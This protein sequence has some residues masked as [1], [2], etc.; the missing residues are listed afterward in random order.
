MNLYIPLGGGT[1]YITDRKCVEHILKDNFPNYEKTHHF[2]EF[3]VD[4]L[5]YGV[6]TTDGDLWKLHRKTASHFFSRNLLREATNITNNKM[7]EIVDLMNSRLTNPSHLYE[8]SDGEDTKTI[9]GG[10]I[11]IQDIFYRMT[12]DIIVQMAFGI[13]LNSIKQ[14]NQHEFA[15][16]F[17]SVQDA[18][19]K[20]CP[21]PL[22]KVKKFLRIGKREKLIHEQMKIINKFGEQVI[23]SK[24]RTLESGGKLGSDLL[25]R[26]I[27]L[28][29]SFNDKVENKTSTNQ[30]LQ[31][32]IM[33]FVLAGRD[34]TA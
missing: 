18:C 11:D 16:A 12:I 6:F 22:F 2:R 19:S 21:D 33:N 34:T 9:Q 1:H 29:R 7:A 14:E 31:D 25:S 5:G 3:L 32:T 28:S 24:R 23:N 10:M 8:I 4:L 20:R 17:D 26:Y 27:D 13:E 30:Q 15:I